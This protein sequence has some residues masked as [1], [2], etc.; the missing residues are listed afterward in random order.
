MCAFNWKTSGFGQGFRANTLYYSSYVVLLFDCFDSTC[1]CMEYGISTLTSFSTNF[2]V[3][4]SSQCT[5]NV[6]YLSFAECF[7]KL[8]FDCYQL[9][10]QRI[11]K[12]EHLRVSWPAIY[13]LG[14]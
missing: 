4:L 5:E 14:L 6:L 11:R 1:C 8:W 13:L 12:K 9:L 7:G 10:P 2:S 3:L